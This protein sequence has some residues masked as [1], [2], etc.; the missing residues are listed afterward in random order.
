MAPLALLPELSIAIA[1]DDV[2]E[3]IDVEAVHA[4]GYEAGMADGR[5]QAEAATAELR[6]R[7]A[8]LG[9][10]L[11]AAAS[12]LQA[13]RTEAADSLTTEVVDA[14][15]RLTE[16]LLGRELGTDPLAAASLERAR[17]LV[18]VGH[19]VVARVHPDDVALL[20]ATGPLAGVELVSDAAVA[21]GGCIV[22]AGDAMVD[23]SLPAALERAR[24]MLLGEDE[25]RW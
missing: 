4:A 9:R 10:G 11:A 7:L 21:P 15:M 6:A 23:G 19:A 13:A 20:T 1:D 2:V 17:A 14:V 24:L 22:T 16:A 5:R 25:E 18:P 3:V 12:E 8:E